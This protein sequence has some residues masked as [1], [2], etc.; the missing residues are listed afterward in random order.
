[1]IGLFSIR[2]KFKKLMKGFDR[3]T[4]E[5]NKIIED[6]D[7]INQE[8]KYQQ[9]LMEGHCI[10]VELANA[11]MQH[12]HETVERITAEVHKKHN[13]NSRNLIGTRMSSDEYYPIFLEIT[14]RLN[15]LNECN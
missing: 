3:I 14:Q 9:K 11:C 13:I 6:C 12:S 15:E 2:K 8:L 10:M 1:M 7:R 4:E 5:S